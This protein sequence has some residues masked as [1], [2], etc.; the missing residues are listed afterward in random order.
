[1]S[2]CMNRK[3]F[4]TVLV[5]LVLMLSCVPALGEDSQTETVSETAAEESV[6]ESAEETAE[7]PAE[8]TLEETGAGVEEDCTV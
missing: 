2:I 6:K 3:R 8:E 7:A 4:W 5:A 1:M